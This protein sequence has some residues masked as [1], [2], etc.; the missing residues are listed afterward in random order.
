MPTINRISNKLSQRKCKFCDQF[1]A[2]TKSVKEVSMLY[3]EDYHPNCYQTFLKQTQSLSGQFSSLLQSSR[4]RA[5]RK[6]WD[7]D[8][9]S[10]EYN[11]LDGI[12]FLHNLYLEQGKRCAV[13]GMEFLPNDDDEWSFH[14]TISIDR[15][16]STKGYTRSNVQL[17]CQCVNYLKSNLRDDQVNEIANGI[18]ATSKSKQRTTKRQAKIRR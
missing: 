17:V 1:L 18:I 5:R 11:D 2:P 16:D 9:S 14:R 7:Y 10:D 6:G 12:Q 4:K 3:P 8:L 13:S 15:R